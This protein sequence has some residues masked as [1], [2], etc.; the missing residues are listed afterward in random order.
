VVYSRGGFLR[1]EGAEA[2]DLG[3]LLSEVFDLRDA[4]QFLV[5]VRY[6]L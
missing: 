3:D 6:R 5:K 4:D 1:Q 2:E